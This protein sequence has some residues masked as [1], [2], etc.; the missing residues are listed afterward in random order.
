MKLYDFTRAP[1]PRRVRIFAAEKGLSI[2]S[3]QVDILSGKARTPEFLALNPAGGVPV[4]ELDDGGYLAESDAIALYLERLNPEPNLLGRDAREQATILMW[5]RRTELN[6]YVRV[7][8]AFQHGHPLAAARI[9]KQ[10]KEYAEFQRDAIVEQLAWMNEQ[11]RGREFVAGPRFTIADI[12][13]L[14]TVDFGRQVE[15]LKLD[16]AH[17]ELARWYEAVS[18]RPSAQA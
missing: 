9:K 13:A 8:H 7:L 17:R 12:T 5:E 3:E 2:P 6:L 11:L 18:S 15:A 1:S 4:L 10:I 14:V 16:P